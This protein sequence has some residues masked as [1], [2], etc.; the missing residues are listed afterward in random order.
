[1]LLQNKR[2]PLGQYC[3]RRGTGFGKVSREET[4]L[5]KSISSGSELYRLRLLP[6][7]LYGSG[8]LIPREGGRLVVALLGSGSSAR[9]RF[10]KNLRQRS[11]RLSI[12]HDSLR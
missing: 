5:K 11:T 7:G 9:G 8:V 10:P 12:G 6:L 2:Y 1:M 3:S 4:G